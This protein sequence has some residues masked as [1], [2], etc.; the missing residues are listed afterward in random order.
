MTEINQFLFSAVPLLVFWLGLTFVIAKI[1]GWSTLAQKFPDKDGGGMVDSRKFFVSIR[2]RFLGNY[3][4]SV[5]FE[6]LPQGLR[7]KVFLPLKFGHD[8]I[9]IPWDE[10]Q[11]AQE[12][13]SLLGMYKF[14]FKSLPEIYV[15]TYRNTGRWI[16]K[17][18]LQY[19]I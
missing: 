11:V 13:S 3:K 2:M 16:A 9:L 6:V 1:S 15:R 8:D 18:K 4:S 17:H 7:M 10:L 19:H 12:T 5:F 14:T